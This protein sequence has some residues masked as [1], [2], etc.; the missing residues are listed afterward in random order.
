MQEDKF[1][2]YIR[3]RQESF[4]NYV[5]ED[6][7]IDFEELCSKV[8]EIFFSD[9]ENRENSGVSLEIQKR[10]IIGYEKE[11]NYFKNKI[12]EI[13]K[14]CHAQD[15]IYPEYYT[16]L[17]DAIFNENYGF[18]GMAEWF[19]SKYSNSSSAKIVGEN[20]FFMVNGHM[21]LMPQKISY[22]RKEQLIKA[23]LLFTPEERMDKPYYE[24][25][26]LDG[27]RVTIFVEPMAKKGQSSIIFRRYIIPNLSFEEQ[28]KRGT[29]PSKIIPLFKLMTKIGFNVV[30]LGAVRTAKTT[31]L[32][33]WESYEDPSLEGVM[34]ETD[35]EIP[36]HR[37]LPNAP[38]LQLI[39]DGEELKSIS[40]NLL[41]SDADYFIMAEARD[42]I[43]LDTAVRLASK[44]TKRMKV[45]F[46]SRNPYQF[47][48]EAATEIV[49]STGGDIHL[50]MN[51][52]ASSFDYLF[53]FTQ[54][55]DKSQKRLTGIYELGLD[56]DEKICIK[57][58]L[59][60]NPLKDNWNIKWNMSKDKRD[61]SIES[62]AKA[63]KKLKR[64]VDKLNEI[65]VLD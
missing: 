33:T 8:R 45:T 6:N 41:R 30:F 19:D 27:T 65:R 31:F 23:F 18:A 61:Y 56:K 50:T 46:H 4:Y 3:K 28:A 57:E 64:E 32:S 13:I 29:I 36:L 53:Y 43:A 9:W 2:E 21:K 63:Y 39:A 25:Y 22:E 11:K 58:L 5:E 15:T 55:S 16:N 40:K 10:A 52:V 20:I 26:L 24:L 59:T 37:I 17:V 48:L 1:E 62:D 47:P 35:P 42:G 7:L 60:Y 12:E 49:K 54:L 51:K 14:D 38:V 34:V 44:G